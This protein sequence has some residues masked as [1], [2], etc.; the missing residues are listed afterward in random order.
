MHG[1]IA[2]LLSSTTTADRDVVKEVFGEDFQTMGQ[3]RTFLRA[4]LNDTVASLLQAPAPRWNVQSFHALYIACWIHHPV[5]K[6]TFMLNLNSLGA[7][8][9]GTVRTA[10][11]THCTSR[12]SSHLSGS[13]RSASK[14]WNFLNGYRELLAQYELTGGVPYL[15]LKAEG[16]TTGLSG[17]VPHLKSWNHKRKHGVGLEASPFLNA[18][19]T[20]NPL[21]EGRAAENYDKAYEKLLK[22]VLGLKGRMVTVREMIPVLFRKTG[23]SNQAPGQYTAMTN[24][25]LGDA[26]GTYCDAATMVGAGGVRFR[27]G[28]IT[29]DMIASLRAI[30]GSLRADGNSTADRV[31]REIRLTPIDADHSLV[32]FYTSPGV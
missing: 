16:H 3:W 15:L 26:L 2:Q 4:R 5:E 12:K 20:A 25:Q 24:Q 17:I 13:G 27:A 32:A 28:G 9:L 18:L 6:G 29:G 31:Y 8:Q 11:E 14:G 10:Y 1:Q 30:A 19:A 7:N 22:D 23:Y 21:V